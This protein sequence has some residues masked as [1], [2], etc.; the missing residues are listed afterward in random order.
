M[1]DLSHFMI[2]N[3][4]RL[5]F[6]DT[7]A[8]INSAV[9]FI[10]YCVDKSRKKRFSAPAFQGL[11]HLLSLS[12]IRAFLGKEKKICTACLCSTNVIRTGLFNLGNGRP[13]RL[14]TSGTS[15]A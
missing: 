11:T 5:D 10:D 1:T 2:R 9:L 4:N 12:L 15:M 14:G 3:R 8:V 7:N 6:I 13:V